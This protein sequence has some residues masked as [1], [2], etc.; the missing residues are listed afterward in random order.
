MIDGIPKI[1]VRI[2]AYKQETLIKRAID[3]LLRQQDYIYEICVSD[4]CSPD[5][6][7]EVLLEYDKLYPGLFRLNRNEHNLGIFKNIEQ[8]WT[9]PTGD[10]VYG[11]A[12]DDECA[13]GWFKQIID[14]ILKNKID[15]KNELFCIYGDHICRY[16]NGDSYVKHN[17]AIKKFPNEALLLAF[18]GLISNRGACLSIKVLQ[19]YEKVSQ[20]RSHIAEFLQDRQLQMYAQKN[21]YLPSISNVYYS[22]IGV[23]AHLDEKILNERKKIRPYAVKYMESK[24]IKIRISEKN[25]GKYIAAAADFNSRRTLSNFCSAIFY[26]FAS[27]DMRY[28]FLGDNMRHYLFAIKRRLPHSKPIIFS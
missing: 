24:G 4:D 10:I 7:W 11:M 27:F 14:F 3:S 6:T 2:I 22:G 13:E 20:G 25:Y 23:S 19:M 1:S 12:G 16:P 21:Y 8:S 15:Y 26:F 17:N 28:S 5:R 18:R 9:M